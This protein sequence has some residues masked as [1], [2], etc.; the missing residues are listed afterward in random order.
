MFIHDAPLRKLLAKFSKATHSCPLSTD[1]FAR[2]QLFSSHCQ[3][4]HIFVDQFA[5]NKYPSPEFQE[6]IGA[7]SSPSSVCAWIRP[8]TEMT[9]V[10]MSIHQGRNV[11]EHPNSLKVL[12]E[13]SPCLFNLVCSVSLTDELRQI[14][15][16]LA[17][18]ALRPFKGPPPY[19]TINTGH[20]FSDESFFPTLPPIRDRGHY[21]AD[22]KQS[23]VMP[24]RCSKVSSSH[25]SLLPGIF[26]IF[27]PHGEC[28][29]YMWFVM[30][31]GV[32]CTVTVLIRWFQE[33][34][35]DFK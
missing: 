13:G 2:L 34:A 19:V 30:Q 28:V 12:Q 15:N 1:E 20:S 24:V 22:K 7:I 32:H 21:A 16:M 31:L 6:F 33:Y 5:S 10:L 18:C 4:L 9:E 35:M 8:S 14:I 25:P 27:C 23:A 26:T 3:P 11:R 29:A 17:S